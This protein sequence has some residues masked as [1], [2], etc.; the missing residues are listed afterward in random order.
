MNGSNSFIVRPPAYPTLYPAANLGW[1]VSSAGNICN[2][3]L[4]A[5][6]MGAPS[7]GSGATFVLCGQPGG[8]SSAVVDLGLLNDTTGFGVFGLQSGSELG[9]AVCP[10]GKMSGSSNSGLLMAAPYPN[11]T[12]YAIFG[13]PTSGVSGAS[14]FSNPPSLTLIPSIPPLITPSGQPSDTGK[15]GSSA[16]GKTAALVAAA[17]LT[18]HA[19]H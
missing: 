5:L 4:A 8:Q 7:L 15:E 12:T 9:T 16:M 19:M 11:G 14:T 1:S 17:L 13:P 18:R 6:A 3:G 10:T 2:N